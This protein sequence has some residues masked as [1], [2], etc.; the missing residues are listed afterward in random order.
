MGKDVRSYK[1]N[2]KGVC[3]KCVEKGGCQGEA[4]GVVCGFC[5]SRTFLSPFHSLSGVEVDNDINGRNHDFGGNEHND[6]NVVF[7]ARTVN[8]NAEG[9]SV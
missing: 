2:S 3:V 6:Y 1:K 5:I 4:V 7:I 8:S 9:K